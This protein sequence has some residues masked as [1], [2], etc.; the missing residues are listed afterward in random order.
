MGD[1][2]EQGAWRLVRLPARLCVMLSGSGRTLTNLLSAIDRG[3]LSAKVVLVIASRE[4][5]GAEIARGAGITTRVMSGEI[6]ADELGSALREHAVDVVALAGYLRK[7]H[8]PQEWRGRVVNIHP[9]L[10]PKF[11]GSGMY[12]DRVHAAV[13]ASGESES[14]CSV[15]LVD[16]EYDRGAVLLQRRCP[17][18]PGDD[19]KSLAARVFLEECRAFP[20]ALQQFVLSRVEQTNG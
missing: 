7:L 3:E 19:V 11:G 6:P 20:E 10:L 2:G 5:P 12:G 17:V 15:H 4:C 16:E 1:A 8:V 18:L 13:L 14:G 9:S